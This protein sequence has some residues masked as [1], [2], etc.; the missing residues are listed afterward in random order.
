MGLM[1]HKPAIQNMR[2][3]GQSRRDR[4]ISVMA[5]SDMSSLR[6]ARSASLIVSLC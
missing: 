2:L 5:D 4:L 3:L 6:M 1:R